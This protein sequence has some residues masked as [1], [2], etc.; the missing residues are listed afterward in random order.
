[1]KSGNL[2]KEIKIYT[3]SQGNGGPQESGTKV[4]PEIK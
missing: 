2:Y 4:G 1:M 3:K